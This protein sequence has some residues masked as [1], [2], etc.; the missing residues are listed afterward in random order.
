MQEKGEELNLPRPVYCQN[1]RSLGF[2]SIPIGESQLVCD[3]LLML[4][5]AMNVLLRTLEAGVAHLE[6]DLH[7]GSS[8]PIQRRCIVVP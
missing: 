7:G 1:L 6:L 2:V 4:V 3:F 8:L 5:V